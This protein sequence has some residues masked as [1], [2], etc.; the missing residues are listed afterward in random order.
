MEVVRESGKICDSVKSL[1]RKV[2]TH[3][4]KVERRAC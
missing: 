3:T 1:L 2:L 4:Q